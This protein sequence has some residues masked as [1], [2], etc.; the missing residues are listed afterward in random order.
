MHFI[1]KDF[2]SFQDKLYYIV[3][4]VREDDKPIVDNLK[5]YLQADIVLK[6]EERFYFLRNIPDIDII[7]E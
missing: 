1:R 2:I 7:T 4:I 3:K 5:E 6:K